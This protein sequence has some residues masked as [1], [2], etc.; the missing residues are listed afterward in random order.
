MR[1]KITLLVAIIFFTNGIYAQ[2]D[3]VVSRL[4]GN[5][6]LGKKDSVANWTIHA[7]LT[8]IY[9]YHPGFKAA[10][11]GQNS[12]RNTA[13]GALS[14]TSTIFIGRKLWKGAAIYFNPELAGGSGLSRTTGVAGF[15]NGEIYRVGNPTPTPFIARGYIQQIIALKHSEYD[16]QSTDQNQLAGKIPTSRVVITLGRFCLA[17]FYDDNGYA[18]DARSQFMNW[19]LMASGAWDFPADVRGYTGGIV[20]EV[21]KPKWAIRFSA[22]QVPTQANGLKMDWHLN[23]AN[24]ET[25]EFEKRWKVKDHL[26]VARATAIVSFS[27]APYYRDA[28]RALLTG[29]SASINTLIPVI[30]AQSEW[31][32]FGGVKYGFA[33]NLEQDMGYGIGLFARGSWNDGHSATWAFT[34]IDHS[35]TVGMNMTGKVWKRP[36]DNFGVAGVLNGISPDHRNYLAAGGPGFIIGD[37]KLRYGNELVLETFY[38]AQLASFLWVSVDYQFIARPAY[39]M[40]RGPAHVFGARVH[41]EI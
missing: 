39:N 4:I 16:V 9:Q 14:L 8:A 7:Q 18:H 22:V 23:K 28:T 26:G 20:V 36:T 19:A 31:N 12:L 13:E 35:A 24:S 3:N 5:D 1:L 15:P 33:L 27:K 11:S 17:D 10:Y 30:S 25:V 29:D 37:G 41:L 34:E 32:K 38:R 21:I 40:D 6:R 2:K